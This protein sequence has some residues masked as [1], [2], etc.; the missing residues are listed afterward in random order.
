MPLWDPGHEL[1]RKSL[2]LK[3]LRRSVS[4]AST[5]PGSYSGGALAKH[6]SSP[7]MTSGPYFF[8]KVMVKIPMLFVKFLPLDVG[9]WGFV[10]HSWATW[11]FQVSREEAFATY[12]RMILGKKSKN[13]R[14]LLAGCW[15]QV[16]LCIGSDFC[17]ATWYKM[18]CQSGVPPDR[19]N[20]FLSI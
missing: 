3:T 8:M 16:F 4:M 15:D 20:I 19:R 2:A 12:V 5:S 7:S 9:M 18:H 6:L 10:V 1:Q 11:V 13:W 17:L 14:S